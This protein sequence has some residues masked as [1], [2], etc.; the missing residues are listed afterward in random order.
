MMAAQ[1]ASKPPPKITFLAVDLWVIRSTRT[2]DGEARVLYY[3]TPSIWNRSPPSA[4]VFTSY[5]AAEAHLHLFHKR[6]K[7]PKGWADGSVEVLD[8]VPLFTEILH[9]PNAR[10]IKR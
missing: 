2:K 1:H 5:E 8:V 4:T 7:A 3:E 10:V 9:S 6:D